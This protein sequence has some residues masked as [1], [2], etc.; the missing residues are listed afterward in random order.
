MKS[1]WLVVSKL[2]R[3]IWGILIQPLKSLKDL[4]FNVL[5]LTKVYN[6]WSKKVQWSYFSWH[7]RVMQ[8]LKKSWLVVSKMAWG[9]CKFSTLQS[10]KI[11]TLMGWFYPKWNLYRLK[12]YREL[13]CHDNEERWMIDLSVEN[14]HKEFAEFWPPSTQKS[15]TLHFNGLLLTKVYNA[16]AKKVQR[17]YVWW[18]W[19]LVQNLKENWLV[20]PKLTWGIWKIFTRALKSP[21][22]GIRSF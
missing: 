7:W 21:K 10:F 5:I 17:S 1:N 2:T 8:N 12:I 13:M 3:G 20:L 19:K 18:H 22:I 14:W 15:Q 4:H 11:W 9:I 16:W 6:F